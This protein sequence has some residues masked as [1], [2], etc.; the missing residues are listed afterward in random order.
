MAAARLQVLLAALCF[1]TTGTAQALGPDGTDPVGVGAAR[2]LVGGDAARRWSRSP[3][4]SGTRPPLGA[5]A[6][7]R[8]RS[9][10]SPPTSSRS[11]R[12]SPTPAWR[13]ARS[14]RSARRPRSPAC[15][16]GSSTAAGPEPR[17]AAAT[18]LACAGVALLALAGGDASV[19]APGIALAVVAGGA[20]AVYTLA[21]KRLLTAGHAPE[22]VMAVA[23]GL[24]AV[25][26]LPALVAE[27][28]RL[29]A[30]RRR[31]RARAVPRRR[32]RPRSR[33]CC[34]PAACKRLSASE[35]AT[36][37]LAEPL[38]AGVLGAVVLAEPMTAMS[39]AGAGLVLAGLL[40]L[41]VRLPAPA[42]A[43]PSAPRHDPSMAAPRP[44]HRTSTVDA[45]A[46]ALQA[47]DPRRRAARRL[48]AARARAVRGL[49]RRAPL[50]ARRAARARRR[51]AGA[52]RAAP[53]R[54][55]R[56]AQR[57]RRALAVRAARGARARGRAPGARAQRRAA[58]AAA[59]TRRSARLRGGVRGDDPPWS[60]I[61]EAHADL[62]AAIVAAARSPRIT[63]AH[64][65]LSGEMRLFL[66]A[67][68]PHIPA[69]QLAA[70]HA[71][72]V[73]GSSATARRSCASTCARPADDARLTQGDRPG[74]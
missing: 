17:W 8:P 71:A 47:R 65:A 2:I 38:T 9:P 42:V 18:A 45:L 12:P 30:A 39:A 52:D 56:R 51:G 6:R 48:A 14:W 29:A 34:S 46:D 15:S 19:S 32:S 59:S 27:R 73:A 1:A 4:G 41:G 54:P 22:A 69:E 31:D 23:F 10:A 60:A 72:L 50:A 25:V 28:A 37:T 55:R 40:A 66:L 16:S 74:G 5:R 36:L 44:L 64:A 63:A 57:R 68:R 35:T 49:R 70:D 24:G 67:L 3:R 7:A 43:S 33:T 61:N 26:L 21:A 13:S 58:A 20:Y 11:S 53:R 62:H